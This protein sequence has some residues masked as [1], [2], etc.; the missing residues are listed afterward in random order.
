MKKLI[1]FIFILS[2]SSLFSQNIDNYIEMLRSDLK[3][4]KTEIISDNISLTEAESEKFWPVYREYSLK[5]DKISDKR[6]KYIKEYADNFDTMTEKKADKIVDQAFNYYE[7]RISLEKK[8]YKKTKKILGVIKAAKL[9]QL[10]HQI[11]VLIDVEI[12]SQLP[13]IE[14]T[15]DKTTDKK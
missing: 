5:L 2:T 15:A 13:L 12:G 9:V 4:K 8:L 7:D 1:L 6:V 14:K 10:E 11:N 3:T